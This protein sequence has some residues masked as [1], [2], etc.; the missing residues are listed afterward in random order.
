MQTLDQ[1][2]LQRLANVSN[3]ACIS[4]YMPTPNVLPEKAANPLQLKNLLKKGLQYA[5]DRK[6]SARQHMLQDMFPFIEALS[7][8]ERVYVGVASFA[9]D[10]KTDLLRL[11]VPVDGQ[12][13]L[14]ESFCVKPLFWLLQQNRVYSLL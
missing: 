1:E 10:T 7:A 5:E 11:P 14:D 2:L 9:S 3:T 4:I 13:C 6:L 8:W 12:I